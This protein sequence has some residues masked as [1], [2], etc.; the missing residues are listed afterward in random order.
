MAVNKVVYSGSTLID[1]TGDSVT[2][3]TLAK[4]ATAHNASGD[5]ITGTLNTS[6]SPMDAYLQEPVDVDIDGDTTTQTMS[7]GVVVTTVTT[8]NSEDIITSRI[9]M[10]EGEYDY[11]RETVVTAADGIDKIRTTLTPITK[12]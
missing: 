4:G 10:N 12:T 9:T 7:E 1:L 6:T 3:E 2:P 8:S 11:I 5:A